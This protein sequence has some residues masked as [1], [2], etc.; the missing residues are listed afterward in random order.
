MKN[1]AAISGSTQIVGLLG[2]P[3]SHSLSP[4][5]HN[6]AFEYL[7]LDWR[8]VPLPVDPAR[9]G[10]I[11]QAVAG[12][13]ALGLRGA[14]VTVPHKQAVMSCVDRLAPAAE[15]IGAVNTI[16]VEKDGS[17][18]GDNTDAAGFIG[19]LRDHGLDLQDRHVLVLG[20][21]GSAR[22]IVY[23]LAQAGVAQIAIANRTVA[24]AQA[25]VAALQPHVRGC[26]IAAF[27]LPA[28]LKGL[29]PQADLIVNCTSLGMTPNVDTCPWPQELPFRSGQIVYDLVY[30]PADTRLLRQA[31]NS[32]AQAI[33][34]LGMLVW[35]GAFAFERWTGTPAPVDIMRSAAEAHFATRTR[36]ASAPTSDLQVRFARPSDAVQIS[37][38]NAYV[39]QLHADAL[40]DF[41]KRPSATSFPA[42]HVLEIM[43]RPDTVMFLA[44]RAGKA[45]GYLYADVTPAME[46]SSTYTFD[47]LH[48]H[49]ISVL[50]EAQ[51]RGCGTALI[52]AAKQEARRRGIPRLALGTWD[53]NRRAQRFF[54]SQG[55]VYYD[56]R[57]WLQGI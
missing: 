43:A 40:P 13:L 26:S 44:E 18:L 20:A 7:N 42:E 30:N 36:E 39:L 35:Q 4:A 33:G 27:A 15:A 8:Y 6:A 1:P 51:G 54:E 34:G 46:S 9:T 52:E 3:V 19:D 24:A 21:G 12:L 32:G 47:R 56:H 2:W 5:M 16:A 49:H 17:L 14:N 55:F 37:E 41:F 23:G 57:M 10:A 25:L 50:P 31:A 45:V 22:A 48:I 53:F 28:D 29:A 38:L 11:P